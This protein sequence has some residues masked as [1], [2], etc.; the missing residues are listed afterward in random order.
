MVEAVRQM[1][2][3]TIVNET[4]DRG[5]R[6]AAWLRWIARGMGSLM[7]GFWLV[8]AAASALSAREPWTQE[9]T[10]IALFVLGAASGVLIGWRRE[11][12]G[13][14]LLV[15]VGLA[16]SAF[17]YF[18]A[19]RNKGYAMLV[20]GGPFLIVGILFLAAWWRSTHSRRGS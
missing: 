18:S 16:F 6:A 4:T 14:T 8:A 11:R 12:I 15:I 7:A 2:R 5:G 10:L 19:G 13:G 17:A 3:R 20:S 1:H 9:S